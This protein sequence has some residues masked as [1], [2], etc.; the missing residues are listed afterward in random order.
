MIDDPKVL[1]AWVAS[2]AGRPRVAVIH[3]DREA[4]V[5]VHRRIGAAVQAAIG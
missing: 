5:E 4:N 1:G 2:P 3:T